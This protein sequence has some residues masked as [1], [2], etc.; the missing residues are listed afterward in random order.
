MSEG[1]EA[2]SP[3]VLHDAHEA[4][5]VLELAGF[6]ILELHAGIPE[7]GED[8]SE[9]I[10]SELGLSASHRYDDHGIDFK[11]SATVDDGQRRLHVEGI[12]H[13]RAESEVE[14]ASPDVAREFGSKVA[15]MSI[16]PYLRQQMNDIG[17]R[18]G[19]DFTLPILRQGDWEL[20][21]P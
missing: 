16:Y 8:S 14:W 15:M 3:L 7:P 18:V 12:V 21:K 11:C 19:L 1:A 10:D 13:F 9:T 5:R 17:Q 20:A 2:S 4:L 6:T